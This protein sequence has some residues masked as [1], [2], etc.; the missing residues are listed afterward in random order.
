[1]GTMRGSMT[2]GRKSEK[3]IEKEKVFCLGSM[4]WEVGLDI[5]ITAEIL[6]EGVGVFIFPSYIR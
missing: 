2:K 1:M 4:V 6:L 5:Y 3:M